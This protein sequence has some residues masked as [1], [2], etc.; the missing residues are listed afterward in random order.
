MS[1]NT[2]YDERRLLR[3]FYVV[4]FRDSSWI[5]SLYF[6]TWLLFT[7][8]S[9]LDKSINKWSKGT[10]V[11]SRY[12]STIADPSPNFRLNLATWC[13]SRGDLKRTMCV[14]CSSTSLPSLLWWNKLCL[15]YIALNP[16]CLLA[17]ARSTNSLELKLLHMSNQKKS[18]HLVPLFFEEFINSKG[19]PWTNLRLSIFLGDIIEWLRVLIEK[20]DLVKF[21]LKHSKFS[22]THVSST[23][24]QNR[25]FQSE[26]LKC[27]FL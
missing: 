26:I 18:R 13:T 6:R 9:F 17:V 21:G 15:M 1:N 3:C 16:R 24:F 7:L 11:A 23:F 27:G 25:S 19:T 2:F 10:D 5:S 22:N 20:I 8:T 14:F 12:Q 4:P